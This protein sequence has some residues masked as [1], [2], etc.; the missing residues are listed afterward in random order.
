MFAWYINLSFVPEMFL[1]LFEKFVL[2]QKVETFT[3]FL[4]TPFCVES[5]RKYLTNRQN[6][7]SN[8]NISIGN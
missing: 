6:T 3:I 5:E 7:I 8:I 1:E 2:P 4:Y